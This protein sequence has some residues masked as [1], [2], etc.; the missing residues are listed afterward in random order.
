MAV[1]PSSTARRS[2]PMQ[3]ATP[4]PPARPRTICAALREIARWAYAAVRDDSRSVLH[5]LKS[6]A[7]SLGTQAIEAF[8]PRL[9]AGR[10]Q[11]PGG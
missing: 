11:A 10:D 3:I 9:P 1:C 4:P 6:K 8:A 2:A 5:L 7:D